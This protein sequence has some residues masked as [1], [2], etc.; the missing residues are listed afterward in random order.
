MTEQDAKELQK[1][2]PSSGAPT[3][4]SLKWRHLILIMIKL[5]DLAHLERKLLGA[6]ATHGG[7]KPTNLEASVLH[8]FVGVCGVCQ[9]W[10]IHHLGFF[11]IL[12]WRCFLVLLR[13]RFFDEHSVVC[14]VGC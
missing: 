11:R 3:H 10:E 1:V 8:L 2:V 5:D 6:L 9:L 13:H 12:L 14:P 4:T 7:D